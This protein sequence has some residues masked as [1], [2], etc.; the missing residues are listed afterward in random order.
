MTY[1]SGGGW[2]EADAPPPAPDPVPDGEE[3]YERIDLVGVGGMGRVFEAFDRQL[4]RRVALKEIAPHLQGADA[5]DRLAHEA[6][7][8]A[9]L[10]HPGIV[11]VHDAGR[12]ADGRLFYTMR[13]VRGRSLAEH[14]D[15]E[16]DEGARR[17]LLRHLLDACHAVSYAHARDIVHRDLKPANIMIGGFGETQVVDWGLARRLEAGPVTGVAGT[18]G[19]MAPEAADG[20]GTDA[21]ADVWSLGA[22]LRLVMGEAP[23][24][25]LAAIAERAVAP[26]PQDRYPDAGELARDIARYLD[27]RRVEAHRYTPGELL[28]RFVEAW[29][30]PLLVGALAALAL[31][32]TGVVSFV[33]NAQARDRAQ[34]AEADARSAL[35]R[36]DGYLA[37]SLEAQA[38]AAVRDGR[39]PSAEVLAAR[40]LQLADSP[41]ARGVLMA[42]GARP[43]PPHVE[44][45]PLVDCGGVSLGEG[46][47]LCLDADGLEVRPDEGASWRVDGPIADAVVAGMHVVVTTPDRRFSLRRLSD[48][49]VVAEGD[50]LPGSRRMVASPS[51]AR[52]GMANG[53]RLTTVDVPSG[54]REDVAIC[55]TAG[56]A[57]ALAL[58]DDRAVVSCR[59]Q[60][61]VEVDADGGLRDFEGAADLPDEPRVLALA[62]GVVLG[63]TVDGD[64]MVFDD[65][66]GALRSVDRVLDGPVDRL[67]PVPGSRWVAVS[68]DRSGVHL[69]DTVARA[70]VMRLPAPTR[71]VRATPG[72]LH[73]AGRD[74]RVWTLPGDA[75]PSVLQAPAGVASLAVSPDG[76]QVA[77]ARGDGGVAVWS[78]DTGRRLTELR[79]QERVAKWVAFSPDGTRLLSIGLG[80]SSVRTWDTTTWS[81]ADKW[82]GGPYR[83]VGMLAD[84]RVWA[85]T[86]AP[87][88]VADVRPSPVRADLETAPY[89]AAA[90]P[91][92]TLA[93]FIDER[94]RVLR[95]RSG[96][97]KPTVWLDR[98]GP[99]G[100]AVD[101]EGGAALAFEKTIEVFS[102]E[103]SRTATLEVDN[104]AVTDVARSLDGRRVAAGLLDGRVLV[105][106]AARPR[107]RA[108]LVGHE[109]RVSAVAFSAD[110]AWLMSADWDGV[111]RRWRVADVDRSAGDLRDEVARAWRMDLED[112]LS[113][114][115]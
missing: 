31:T 66:T 82:E 83:R 17:G 76:Q 30:T 7:L 15:G 110:G 35:A 78:T 73:V 52:F 20:R 67:V 24:A 115:Q 28:L 96:E 61:L 43:R 57:T 59:L 77:V 72:A 18:E 33:R 112:A 62:P 70:E 6:R 36:S 3:R 79:W 46:A 22:T 48:G 92:G 4:G 54:A 85:L 69:W 37:R 42:G 89:D 21:R 101:G 25:D 34:A 91:D 19:F 68:G 107:P 106:D 114:V 100:I 55:G 14:L 56:G 58:A 108:V 38:A 26:D 53:H 88:V 16:L 81:L 23:A 39:L 50:D 8:T 97:A 65:D 84:G 75:R 29:R 51:G 71:D 103:G 113:V 45:A 11:T 95:L 41:L 104:G 32:V 105:W 60:G 47:T 80:E 87:G 98:A 109:A 49:T 10:E 5:A 86:Y 63:G 13:L 27:G 12:T 44:V 1:P 64:V 102:A 9:E 2:S 40:V 94:G 74:V 111:V 90:T 93:L 99:R